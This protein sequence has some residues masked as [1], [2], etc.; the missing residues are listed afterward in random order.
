VTVTDDPPLLDVLGALREP[1][2]SRLPLAPLDLRVM[3]GDSVLIGVDDPLQAAEFADLC[4]GLIPLRAGSVRFLGADWARTPYQQA[5]TLR[6]RIGQAH[7]ANSWIGFLSADANILLQQ[8]HH[9]RL[10]ESVLRARAAGLSQQFGL[11]GLPLTPPNELAFED[12]VRADLVRAFLGDPRLLILKNPELEQVVNLTP[13]LLNALTAAH[14]QRAA[15]IWLTSS[16][17]LWNDLTLP[18]TTRL[19]LTEHGLISSTP[20]GP[21]S[22]HQ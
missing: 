16:D 12:L 22:P 14:D 18:V 8:L 1:A 21:R 6:G 9:T 4:C 13:A 7:G 19:R 15:S 20:S 3:P 17:I 11:P 10:A 5:S 2:A